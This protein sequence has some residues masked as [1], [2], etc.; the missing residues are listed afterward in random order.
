MR[1]ADFPFL[2]Y[3]PFVLLGIFWAQSPFSFNFLSLAI[4]LSLLWGAYLIFVSLLATR[5]STH[6]PSYLGY[7]AL[8][9]LGALLVANKQKQSARQTDFSNSVSYLAEVTMYDQQKPNSFENLLEVKSVFQ[10][11]KWTDAEGKILVYH[12][13]KKPLEPGQILLVNKLPETIASPRNPNEFDYKEYLSR[14]EITYRQFLGKD[15]QVVDSVSKSGPKYFLVHLRQNIAEMLKSKIPDDKSAQIALALLLGQKKELDPTIREAYTQAGVMHILAV[16]GLHVGIIYALFILILKP[17]KMKKEKS[18]LYLLF[19]ILIIW[20]YAFLTGLSPS[21]VRAATMFSLLTLGQ[22]RERRPSIYN[23]LAFSAI[24]MITFNPDVIYEVGFQL[25]YLA[26]FGI[27]MIQPLILNCWLPRSKALEYIWQLIS[28]SLAAQ[29]VT[30]PLS[31]YYFHIFPTYF[32][33]GNMLILPLAF[34]IMQVGV[35]LMIFGWVPLVGDVLGWALSWLI[36]FQNYIAELIRLIPGG[37]LDRLTMDFSGMIL[38]WGILLIATF[39]EF[40]SKRT[41]T[42]M[43]LSL[44]FLWTGVQLY[45]VVN[46]PSKELIVYQGKKS[47]MFDFS[48]FNELYSFNQG[49]EEGEISYSVDRNRIQQ[50]VSQLPKTLYAIQ[51]DSIQLAFLKTNVTLHPQENQLHFTSPPTSMYYWSDGKWV[52]MELRHSLPLDSLAYRILF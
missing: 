20:L 3:L 1:F 41:L 40:G 32:L 51:K 11:G 17:L 2:R 8:I 45:S 47:H 42:W 38:V 52:N 7:L 33:L 16:S 5:K 50:H 19:V 10:E 27:V 49:L 4:I 29:L 15:F 34:V 21:V 46:V 30:F 9:A 43:A 36:W 12:Q 14:Q 6:Q 18:R 39:W 35:P 22:M 48:V 13:N 37:K 28:V 23:I 31:I 26:V 25:S 44:A 24:L